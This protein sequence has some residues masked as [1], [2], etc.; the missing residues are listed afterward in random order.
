[1]EGLLL[2]VYI[3]SWVRTR[4][5]VLFVLR[6]LF[7]GLILESLLMMYLGASGQESFKFAGMKARI[8]DQDPY[9]SPS[10]L[11]L[12]RV[13]GTVG[14]PNGCAGYITMLLAPALSVLF[15]KYRQSLKLLAVLAFFMGGFALVLTF[16]R[17]GW[18][19]SFISVTLLLGFAAR[20]IRI[21]RWILFSAVAA[22]LIAG[23]A[24]KGAISDRLTNSDRGAAESRIPLMH[25][26]LEMIADNPILGV[27]VNNYPVRMQEYATPD[28]KWLYAV[29]N[30]YLLDW[31]EMG[32]GGLVALVWFLIVVVR[33]GFQSWKAADPYLSPIAVGLTAA[34]IGTMLHMMFELYRDALIVWVGAALITA[35]WHQTQMKLPQYS[36][37]SMRNASRPELHKVEQAPRNLPF[38]RTHGTP[39]SR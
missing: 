31:A 6:F 11:G 14:S 29:H 32:I 23:I 2:F 35:I 28:V 37:R 8:N 15:S 36:A 25:T 26:A 34:M 10:A 27:G 7:L 24:F 20:K 19:A 18:L 4:E 9:S 17:G 38:R 1:V 39:P 12:A 5:D 33:R 30:K 21:P 13:G 16:S 3:A 22:I